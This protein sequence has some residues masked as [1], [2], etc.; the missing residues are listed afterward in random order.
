MD[1]APDGEHAVAWILYIRETVVLASALALALAWRERKRQIVKNVMAGDPQ[2]AG[3]RA[4]L[5]EGQS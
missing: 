3:V 5:D 1:G 4:L 2:P